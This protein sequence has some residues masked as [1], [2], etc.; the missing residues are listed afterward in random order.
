MPKRQPA[1]ALSVHHLSTF[2]VQRGFWTQIGIGNDWPSVFWPYKLNWAEPHC[3][4]VFF[5][6]MFPELNT[7]TKILSNIVIP[8][9]SAF[10]DRK[11]ILSID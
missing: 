11:V 7:T 3:K 1:A 10:A 8:L 5:H 9:S 2:Y 4:M 6:G